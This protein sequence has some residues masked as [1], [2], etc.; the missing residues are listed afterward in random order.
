MIRCQSD[1][2]ALHMQIEVIHL[3]LSFLR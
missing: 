3:E 1:L 2:T